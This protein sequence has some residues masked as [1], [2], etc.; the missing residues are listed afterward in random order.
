[1]AK[2]DP[3]SP[4]SF[5]Q[6]HTLVYS[7]GHQLQVFFLGYPSNHRGYIRYK[8]SSRKTIIYRHVNFDENTFPFSTLSA[9][10]TSN[11]DFLDTSTHPFLTP[12]KPILIKALLEQTNTP[13]L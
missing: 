12:V 1:M 7:F 10:S 5:T 13:L 3:A 11:Y 6:T 2:F 4:K 9:P 8:L